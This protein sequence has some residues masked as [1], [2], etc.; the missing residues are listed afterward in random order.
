MH[1]HPSSPQSGQ[2]L[3]VGTPG[4]LHVHSVNRGKMAS[5]KNEDMKPWNLV[6]EG[7]FVNVVLVEVVG[8][9]IVA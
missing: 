3:G 8:D 9:R 4:L 1:G 5:R 6:E 2:Y 7:E